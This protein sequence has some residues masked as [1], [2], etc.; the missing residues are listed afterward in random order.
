MQFPR[1]CSRAVISTLTY[2]P[3]IQAGWRTFGK[4]SDRQST[5]NNDNNQNEMPQPIESNCAPH[6][7]DLARPCYERRARIMHPVP[8]AWKTAMSYGAHSRL[9]RGE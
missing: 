5:T 1:E 6:K 4:G 7:D 8:L 9:V 3:S 2:E